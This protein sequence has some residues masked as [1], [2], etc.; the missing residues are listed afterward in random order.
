MKEAHI[1]SDHTHF[2]IHS[3]LNTHPY[4]Q[5]NIKEINYPRINTLKMVF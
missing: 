3:F 1:N 5:S 4:R 2:I